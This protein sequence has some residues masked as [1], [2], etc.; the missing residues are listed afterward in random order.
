VI[1]DPRIARPLAAAF[2]IAGLSLPSLHPSL[3]AAPTASA[4]GQMD[5]RC[6]DDTFAQ[7]CAKLCGGWCKRDRGYF[8]AHEDF[9]MSEAVFAGTAENSDPICDTDSTDMAS[10]LQL[11]LQNARSSA[12][13]PEQK[14]QALDDPEIVNEL[15]KFI[16]SVPPC[17]PDA[18]SLL[19][20]FGCLTQEGDFISADFTTVTGRGYT[21][22]TDFKQLCVIPREQMSADVKLTKSLKGRTVQLRREFNDVNACRDAYVAWADDNAGKNPEDA[23]GGILQQWID[24]VREELKPAEETARNLD[25]QLSQIDAQLSSILKSMQYGLVLCPK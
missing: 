11:C 20:L 17:A 7:Q 5:P 6:V 3:I 8:L 15:K 10:S 2:L 24:S 1:R 25:N 19:T 16:E 18:P 13:S 21:K 14:L 22:L 23:L 4:A 12:A 9:C